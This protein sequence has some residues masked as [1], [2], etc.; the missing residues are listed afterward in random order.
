MGHGSGRIILYK[1]K[2]EVLLDANYIS[3]VRFEAFSVA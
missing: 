2:Q 3:V 1:E